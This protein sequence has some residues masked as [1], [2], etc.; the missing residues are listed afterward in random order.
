MKLRR[1]LLNIICILVAAILIVLMLTHKEEINVFVY[2]RVNEVLQNKVII[3]DE[4]YNVR[5]YD[6][7]TVEEA[8]SFEPANLDDIRKIYY[9][10]LNNG[11]ERF[12]FYCPA[13][14]KGC[15]D[16]VLS[17][18]K[19]TT[20]YLEINNYYV[21]PYN[22][23]SLYNTTVSTSGE[24]SISVDKLYSNEQIEYLKK[25]VDETLVKLNINTNNPTKED[26]K[27]IHDYIINEVSYDDNYDKTDLNSNSNNAY[28]ALVDHK[29]ICSGYTDAY[30]IFLDRL[31]IKNIKLPSEDHIWNYIYFDNKWYHVDLTWDDDEVHKNNT[32]NFFMIDTTQLHKL[33][34][35]K[36]N[37]DTELFKETKE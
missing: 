2:S 9:T 8:N 18:A 5:N 23:Y 37:F 24:I 17:I 13:E 26:L 29:A 7:I 14:Y 31:N 20:I 3:P 22:N 4:K 32:S 35:E 19:N 12:T 25:Y 27:K 36:H 6:Y 21:S 1:V 33:D 30:A 16:D 11:W 34:T 15:I 10:V 28:G